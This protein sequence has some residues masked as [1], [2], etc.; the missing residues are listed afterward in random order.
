MKQKKITRWQSTANSSVVNLGVAKAAI[1]RAEA[2]VEQSQAVLA[3]SEEDL[4][5][6]T[7]ISPIDGIVLH[8][9]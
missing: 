6:A 2:Q 8:V 5:N 3:Q 9:T 4:R 1:A 7:I